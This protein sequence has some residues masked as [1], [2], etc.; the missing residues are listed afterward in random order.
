MTLESLRHRRIG[1]G[2]A[3]SIVV[4][5]SFLVHLGFFFLYFDGEVQQGGDT[6]LYL[7]L[8]EG[9]FEG[10]GMTLGGVPSAT[11]PPVYPAFLAITAP[12][13]RLGGLPAAIQLAVSASIAGAV[14]AIARRLFGG[15]AALISGVAAIAA[16]QFPFWAGYALSD[17][18]GVALGIWGIWSVVVASGV[19]AQ[20]EM[21]NGKALLLSGLGGLLVS[22]AVLTR[23]LNAPALLMAAGGVIVTGRAGQRYRNGPDSGRRA[24]RPV[25]AAAAAFLLALVLPIAMWTARNA[26]VMRAPIVLSTRTG[27]QLWQGT[28]WELDAR[29]TVG[30]D[31]YYPEEASAMGEVEADRYLT[32][33]SIDEIRAAPLR[34]V[35]KFATKAAYLWLPSA[36]GLGKGMLLTGLYFC[37]LAAL[38]AV[39]LGTGRARPA[40]A[41]FWL[42]ALGVT[43]AVG[44]TIL[45][46]EYRY[47]LPLVVMMLVPAGA[48]F[49]LL[50][51]RLRRLYS[52]GIEQGGR[53]D[54]H[55]GGDAA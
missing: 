42:G 28:L 14:Y 37:V 29:G 25:L 38:A 32:R 53:N 40:S 13:G 18:L 41:P 10:R 19:L 52:R 46:P 15:G 16:P 8:S 50:W 3:V 54:R 39:A 21:A 24:G 36:P 17:A 48:G 2:A 5:A 31:V 7:E 35:Y 4:A 33:R 34:Y 27:W 12:G 20:D 1:P 55:P 43:V 26:V 22:L 30:K 11:Y 49:E 9:F 45:D 6:P 44:V 47:R 51:S 23:P